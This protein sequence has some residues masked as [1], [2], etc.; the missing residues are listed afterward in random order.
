ML[1]NKAKHSCNK[2]EQGNPLDTWWECACRK[3]TQNHNRLWK[4]IT[5]RKKLYMK[6]TEN[7]WRDVL[8]VKV[9]PVSFTGAMLNCSRVTASFSSASRISSWVGPKLYWTLKRTFGFSMRLRLYTGG[10][11]GRYVSLTACVL[12]TTVSLWLMCPH[13]ESRKQRLVGHENG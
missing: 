3:V 2:N 7:N 8:S 10:Q 4:Q 6:F 12:L 9:P 1:S 5:E 13:S 11:S